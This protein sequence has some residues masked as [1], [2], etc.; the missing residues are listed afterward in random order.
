[1]SPDTAQVIVAAV[2]AVFGIY[3]YFANQRILRNQESLKRDFDLFKMHLD[4]SVQR[5][6]HA[7][8]LVNQA[9]EAELV[10]FHFNEQG[11]Q[12]NWA[13]KYVEWSTCFAELRGLAFAIDDDQLWK[14]INSDKDTTVIQ[15]FVGKEMSTRLYSQKLH[16]RINQLLQEATTRTESK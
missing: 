6:Q 7:R 15:G 4:Q 14:L 10:M 13:I 9:H 8:E 16:T 2:V 12:E 3:Q 11:N 1:M 5:L